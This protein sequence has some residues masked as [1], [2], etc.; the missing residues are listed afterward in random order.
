MPPLLEQETRVREMLSNQRSLIVN[1]YKAGS[2]YFFCPS[3]INIVANPSLAD[4]IVKM[5]LQNFRDGYHHFIEDRLYFDGSKWTMERPVKCIAHANINVIEKNKVWS[6]R[7]FTNNLSRQF[8][9]NGMKGVEELS[10]ISTTRKKINPFLHEVCQ[11]KNPKATC[12]RFITVNTDTADVINVGV[13]NKKRKQFCHGDVNVN[14]ANVNMG[15][16]IYEAI[17]LQFQIANKYRRENPGGT[18]VVPDLYYNKL[19]NSNITLDAVMSSVRNEISILQKLSLLPLNDMADSSHFKVLAKNSFKAYKIV[20]SIDTDTTKTYHKTKG[21]NA[22]ATLEV[23]V[24]PRCFNSSAIKAVELTPIVKRI[25]T[26]ILNATTITVDL[27]LLLCK[28]YVERQSDSLCGPLANDFCEMLC[29]SYN[30]SSMKIVDQY[31]LFN[32]KCIPILRKMSW[33]R[34]TY[35][36]YTTFSNVHAMG[37]YLHL[38]DQEQVSKKY[39]DETTVKLFSSCTK[40]QQVIQ[41]T[42]QAQRPHRY[43][44]NNEGIGKQQTRKRTADCLKVDNAHNT[45][46]TTKRRRCQG[47]CGNLYYGI[48]QF[49]DNYDLML[50]DAIEF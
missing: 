12:T 1:N 39:A 26:H 48:N 43:T 45:I 18:I 38:E 33:S 46:N 10:T 30:T 40:Y 42:K 47:L 35:S 2:D 3:K 29:A 4:P 23:Q 27:C 14:M 31:N 32:D 49:Y 13:K 24:H 44:T 19:N 8:I 16:G 7:M 20:A 37:R 41:T 6:I 15:R 5:F 21:L 50:P 9:L 25:Y 11:T 36:Q 28:A 34:D 17:V 22:A